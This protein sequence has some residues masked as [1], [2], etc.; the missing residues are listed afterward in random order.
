MEAHLSKHLK[1]KVGQFRKTIK[2][3]RF[4]LKLLKLLRKLRNRLLS[5]EDSLDAI[6]PKLRQNNPQK[7]PK[8]NRM[9]P[10]PTNTLKKARV[11]CPMSS[12]KATSLVRILIEITKDNRESK[13]SKNL[14]IMIKKA[15]YQSFCK[16]CLIWLKR[17]T[18]WS[19]MIFIWSA[20]KSSYHQVISLISRNN[21]RIGLRKNHLR[22]KPSLSSLR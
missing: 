15:I 21:F 8:K 10:I 1:V 6:G 9:I 4:N 7:R 16:N 20:F 13:L 19:T 3:T 2:A 18:T 17:R 5:L 11:K 22:K 14:E 12:L